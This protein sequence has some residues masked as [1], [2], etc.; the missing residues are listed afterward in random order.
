MGI[1]IDITAYKLRQKLCLGR[2]YMELTCRLLN[3]SQFQV[4][5]PVHYYILLK[6]NIIELAILFQCILW[7][8][9][10]FSIKYLLSELGQHTPVNYSVLIYFDNC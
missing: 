6:S 2:N 10:I 5:K 3:K 9:F 7:V 8:F 1:L 4:E